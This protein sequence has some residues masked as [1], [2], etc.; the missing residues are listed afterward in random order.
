MIK[1]YVADCPSCGAPVEF[2]VSSALV[3]ICSSC[4]SVVARG[5]RNLEDHGKV[6]AIVNT[7]SP[8]KLGVEGTYEGERFEL[9]GHLQY[10]HEAGGVW[11]EWYAA[12]PNDRWGWL[13][14]S[15]GKLHLLFPRN[16]AEGAKFPTWQEVAAG[17]RYA[18]PD[19][20][21]LTV[22]EVSRAQAAGAEGELPFQL[23]PG[24]VHN[25]ADLTG[26]DGEFATF[27]YGE[28]PPVVYLGSETSLSELGITATSDYDPEFTDERIASGQVSCPNCGGSLELKA[29]DAALRVSC[30]YCD[31]L[32]DCEQGKLAYLKTLDQGKAQ[33]V[34]PLG[35]V[36]WFRGDEYTVIG[37]MRRSVTYDMDYYWSEYL[38]YSK[39]LGFRWM[40]HSDG[41]WSF[42]EPLP[43]GEVSSNTSRLT[44]GN[45]LNCRGR[46]FRLFQ[47][48]PARVRY[49]LGEFYWKVELDEVVYSRDFVSPPNMISMEIGGRDSE[50]KNSSEI[51][52]TLATYIPHEEI[53]A[54]F[55]VKGLSRGWGVSPNQ[56]SPVDKKVYLWWLVGGVL[57]LLLYAIFLSGMLGATASKLDGG[58]LFWALIFVSA[59][60]GG[61]LIYHYSFEKRRWQ[62]SEFNPYAS[63]DD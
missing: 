44:G 26:P 24:T 45:F 15:Q 56:P 21:S 16:V 27:D 57:I 11:D 55:G 23:A 28:D 4:Q 35:T 51:N 60:P 43:P 63:D 50:D 58:I 32:L 29:P 9:V 39:E 13:S 30:P 53:E 40:I 54:S 17:N 46:S 59:I 41:H 20:G 10:R 34:I 48:A 37:F 1:T 5:D 33:V 14:E 52:L 12:F 38:L 25:F 62:D 42:G 19:V 18:F 47:Q 3:T 2:K 49:V 36:G 22:S 31:A 7:N 8:L 61:A 6:A